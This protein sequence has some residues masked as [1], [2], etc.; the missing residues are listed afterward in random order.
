MWCKGRCVAV[1]VCD[2]ACFHPL[3][4]WRTEDGK[5]VFKEYAD[6]V[7]T[8]QL[9]CGRC[10]GCRLEHSRQWSVRIM[11]EASMHAP[12]SFVTLTYEESKLPAGGALVYEDFQL[13]MKRVRKKFGPTRFFMCG[14]YGDENRRPHFH[15]GL[16]GEY[17]DWETDRKSTRLNSSHE[18]PSRMPSSA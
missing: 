13:F 2:M 12:S 14:E 6:T 1:G 15:A 8:L 4:A 17:R 18:I 7:A 11:H 3:R 10:V 9:P 5:I 16:F